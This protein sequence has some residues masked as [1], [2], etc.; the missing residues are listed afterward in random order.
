MAKKTPSQE[1]R[2]GDWLRSGRKITRL[3]AL[4]ELGIFELSARIKA[5][6]AIGWII[7]RRTIKVTNRFGE[8]VPCKEYWMEA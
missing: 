1:K 5:L 3:E 4:V 6:E 2:L 8:T 7:P